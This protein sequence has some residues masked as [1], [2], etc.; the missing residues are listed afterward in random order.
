MLQFC[1]DLKWILSKYFKY[2]SNLSRVKGYLLCYNPS[3]K[4]HWDSGSIVPKYIE[5]RLIFFK[6]WANPGLFLFIFVL[7][8]N[9]FTEKIVDFSGNRTRIV[10]VE[11]EHAD[12]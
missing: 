7:F 8:N 11:G 1:F 3:A 6:N 10:G 5:T 4:T 2:E 9:N 12:H